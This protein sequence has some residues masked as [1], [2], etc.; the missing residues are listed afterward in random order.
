[1][2]ILTRDLHGRRVRLVKSD[3]DGWRWLRLWFPLKS[4]QRDLRGVANVA[5]SFVTGEK[6][7][8][9]KL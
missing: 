5:A 1:M 4:F 3:V 6:V 2:T 8:R 7:G 9:E